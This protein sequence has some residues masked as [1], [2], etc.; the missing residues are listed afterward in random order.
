MLNADN[1]DTQPGQSVHDKRIGLLRRMR[2]KL[3]HY[4]AVLDYFEPIFNA[5]KMYVASLARNFP[6]QLTDH[7]KYA[8]R[9]QQARPLLTKD[10]IPLAHPLIG[11][12]FIQIANIIKTQGGDPHHNL[13]VILN[14]KNTFEFE[15]LIGSDLNQVH[16]LANHPMMGFLI[17]QTIGPVLERYATK[18]QPI[19]DPVMWPHGFC[20]ICGKKPSFA[21]ITP[22]HGKRLLVCGVCGFQWPFQRIK[23]LFCGNENQQSLSY[24]MVAHEDMYRIETCELCRCY[25]KT[26]DAKNAT[27]ETDYFLEP[28]IT[29]HLDIIAQK[30]GYLSGRCRSSDETI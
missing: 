2:E 5:R 16:W 22:E 26:I 7:A 10:E 3:P 24:L 18:L 25:I 29:L 9:L 15:S 17:D 8:H 13:D 11:N 21:I 30:H 6:I 23:C 1:T 20:P 19:V 4:Q 27:H 14:S 12:Y 28:I